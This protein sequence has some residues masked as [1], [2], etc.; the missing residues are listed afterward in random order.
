MG[1]KDADVGP[2]L[3]HEDMRKAEYDA[4]VAWIQASCSDQNLR[5]LPALP[6]SEHAKP[7]R[8][9][10]VIRHARKSRVVAATYSTSLRIFGMFGLV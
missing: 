5:N 10:E 9:D 1:E 6:D 2:K 4:F 3:I 7:A 8:P